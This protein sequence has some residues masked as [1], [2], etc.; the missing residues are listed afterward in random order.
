M[1]MELQ[2]TDVDL[3]SGHHELNQRA[4][5]CL[6]N[7]RLG[8]ATKLFFWHL[9][10]LCGSEPGIIRRTSAKKLAPPKGSA[11]RFLRELETEGFIV[12]HRYQAGSRDPD[13]I[14][15]GDLKILVCFP[16]SDRS[17]TREEKI[18]RRRNLDQRLFP[19]MDEGQRLFPVVS[20]VNTGQGSG[21]EI[22]PP[23]E[24]QNLNPVFVPHASRQP[25]GSEIV[26]PGE[27]QNLNPVFI[28]QT[29][30]PSRGSK[31]DPDLHKPLIPPSTNNTIKPGINKR[32]PLDLT[33]FK[34]LFPALD[35]TLDR[36]KDEEATSKSVMAH[37]S[38]EDQKLRSISDP[39]GTRLSRG[40]K[41]D[42]PGQ[43][44]KMTLTPKPC[45]KRHPVSSRSQRVKST[46]ETSQH[47]CMAGVTAYSHCAC[48][49][50]IPLQTATTNN[51]NE[52]QKLTPVSEPHDQETSKNAK[53]Y[54][55]SNIQFEIFEY[56][57]IPQ[58]NQI[59]Q[60]EGF[61]LLDDFQSERIEKFEGTEWIQNMIQ[62]SA[63]I[64]NEFAAAG[65]PFPKESKYVPDMVAELIL[66]GRLKVKGE[67]GW[68]RLRFL[69]KSRE[70]PAA[71][72]QT[73]LQDWLGTHLLSE[74]RDA[75]VERYRQR[76][77]YY[78]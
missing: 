31:I 46:A 27:D 48:R 2:P 32:Q 63:K 43:G 12:I 53:P 33:Q 45:E 61:E 20:P 36:R 65:V 56:S 68:N 59:P 66:D 15:P 64:E 55:I 60:I 21:S 28:S 24:G 11:K 7:F 77:G 3:S 67:H 49:R 10:I 72:I 71:Y 62:L 39:A 16:S 74:F 70:S 18:E 69:A 54:N 14:F 38:N 52:G 40:S 23:G 50:E 9:W 5:S 78:R 73:V 19:F 4:F 76:I 41:I 30:G 51:A 29:S 6:M 44:Q 37:V 47:Q 34:F 22:V 8:Y 75:A 26:P 42:P 58:V 25:R 57:Q 1:K 13:L 35:T 17:V